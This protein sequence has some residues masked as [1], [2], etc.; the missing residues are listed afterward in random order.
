MKWRA[1]FVVL[2]ESKP[3]GYASYS[4]R[5]AVLQRAARRFGRER[6]NGWETFCVE[7][8]L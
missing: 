4:A 2:T 3:H 7:V 8:K 6:V 1:V 5:A